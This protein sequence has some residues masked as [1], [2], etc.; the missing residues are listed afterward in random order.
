MNENHLL[1]AISGIDPELLQRSEQKTSSGVWKKVLPLAACLCL[2]AGPAFLL[3]RNKVPEAA[4][5]TQL[6]RC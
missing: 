1:D 4:E 2:I 6:V 3:S 5:P